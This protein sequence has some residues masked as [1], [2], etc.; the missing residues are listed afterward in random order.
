[1]VEGRG[2]VNLSPGRM[3][4][5]GNSEL[6]WEADKWGN[7]SR[8][9]NRMAWAIRNDTLPESDRW[10]IIKGAYAVIG[11]EIALREKNHG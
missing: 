6:P 1:M 8:Q 7:I 11:T 9:L 3:R 2:L 4:K 10:M 5:M